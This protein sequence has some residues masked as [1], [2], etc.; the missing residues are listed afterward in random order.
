MGFGYQAAELRLLKVAWSL[1]F[2]KT[3]HC[4]ISPR[5]TIM[6]NSKQLH[7]PC[8]II[9]VNRTHH[10]H[11]QA[12]PTRV[13]RCP[14]CGGPQYHPDFSFAKEPL[15]PLT[16]LFVSV[17]FASFARQ[18][19]RWIFRPLIFSDTEILQLSTIQAPA[20]LHWKCLSKLGLEHGAQ[21]AGG[22]LEARGAKI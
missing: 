19:R 6:L 3:L 17:S 11:M 20:C 2:K 9:I 12:S 1:K 18:R 13:K 8:V 5:A 15:S 14:S 16:L 4:S 22:H 21:H 7:A 10:L